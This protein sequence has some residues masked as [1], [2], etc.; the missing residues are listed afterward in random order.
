M[1]RVIYAGRTSTDFFHRLLMSDNALSIGTS[2]FPRLIPANFFDV[3]IKSIIALGSGTNTNVFSNSESKCALCRFTFS[4]PITE[5]VI[6][7]PF[8][9]R[10]AQYEDMFKRS[11]SNTRVASFHLASSSPV[12]CGAYFSKTMLNNFDVAVIPA[13]A[14]SGAVAISVRMLSST[15]LSSFI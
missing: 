4:P 10:S 13:L 14:L 1:L 2:P 12:N 11:V 8:A 6:S 5:N 9:W 3:L 7:A 15:A